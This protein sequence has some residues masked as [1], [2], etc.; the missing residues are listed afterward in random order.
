MFRARYAN[1]I[2]LTETHLTFPYQSTNRFLVVMWTQVASGTYGTR[3]YVRYI[4]LYCIKLVV[5]TT[6]NRAL[7]LS[8]KTIIIIAL[9]RQLCDDNR[10]Y[11]VKNKNIII[12]I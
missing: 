11:A 1:A 7:T 4:T 3:P 9:N 12:D 10:R 8:Y 6:Q 2:C 5:E